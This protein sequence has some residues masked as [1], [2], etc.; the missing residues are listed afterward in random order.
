[1]KTGQLEPRL[2]VIPHTEI[3]RYLGCSKEPDPSTRALVQRAAG[4]MMEAI[5]PKVVWRLFDIA[6]HPQG[7]I[8][9]QSGLVLPGQDLQ[10]HLTGCRE[11]VLLAATL[12]SAADTIIRRGQI[13][14]LAFGVALDSSATA[15]IEEIC[16]LAQCS[17]AEDFTDSYLTSRFSPGYGDL[18]ITLQGDLLTLLDAPRRIGLCANQSSILTPRKSVTAFIGISHTPP[19]PS[20]GCAGCSLIKSC[21][22]RRKGL[23]GCTRRNEG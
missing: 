18:P 19:L 4:A 23:D 7:L 16:N 11:V 9:P 6:V 1:M 17:I 10:K 8:L 12:S 5:R 3:L 14:D 13:E 2:T 15:A 22:F 20:T 21:A